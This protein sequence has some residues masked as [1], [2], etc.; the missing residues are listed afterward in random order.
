MKLDK[1]L[2]L[3]TAKFVNLAIHNLYKD[4]IPAM[5]SIFDEGFRVVFYLPSQSKISTNDFNSIK[6]ELSHILNK[7]LEIS[8]EEVSKQQAQ[9][10]FANNKYYLDI[11]SKLDDK[12]CLIHIGDFVDLCDKNDNTQ[13]PNVEFINLNN[14]S[15]HYWNDD[16][17]KEQLVAISGWA[18]INKKQQNEYQEI[19]NDRIER[20]HR[21]IGADLELFCFDKVVGQGLPIWLNN[22]F[23]TKYEIEKYCYELMRRNDYHFVECPV[24]GTT[25][26]YKISGH[27]DHYRENMFS[28]FKVDNEEFVLKP[29][30][31][32]HHITAYKQKPH[33]YRELP[34]RVAEFGIQHRYE[35]SG[36]LTGLERVRSMKL[37]DT[38]TVLMHNQIKSEIKKI[39]QIIK[40]AHKTLGTSIYS[41]DL[42]L[43]DP[44]DKAKFFDNPKMWANA[45]NQ[46]RSALKSLKIPYKE[47]IGEAAFYGPKIDL[48]I[49][50]ALGHIVTIST[51]QLDF[52]L[53]ERFN[54]EYIDA[55]GKRKRP[56]FIHAGIIGTFERY[57]AIL[58]E[59]TKGV[60]PLWLAPI[61]VE[62]IP[63]NN[64][65]HL[66][67]ATQLKKNLVKNGI[68]VK[69]DDSIN[70]LSYKIRDA[71]IHKIPY[72]IVIGDNEIND[73]QKA[74]TYRQYGKTDEVKLP[75]SQ[76]KSLLKKQIKLH[77]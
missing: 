68:R 54:L 72:Q 32:P 36:S 22:G 14:V 3:L 46:L 65:K 7:N 5:T 18:A 40:E 28:P 57:I 76:F 9:I 74:I 15:G 11:I 55:E 58:L 4:A 39:Y 35:S 45:E 77:K 20:D 50:T 43:H 30:N 6:K 37:V 56:V 42:S 1:G 64:E 23:A 47:M 59:Q 60:L 63:I 21:K 34:F 29:M 67:Y 51:I 52:L 2:N 61:Q 41:V 17:S 38:H 24:L 19:I 69:L 31:C 48:Q 66:K 71:Q 33:S 44:N 8:Y 75:F 62:I 70:R 12:I 13:K 53:P 10:L 16:A 26:L 73:H 27:W 25:D 49:K